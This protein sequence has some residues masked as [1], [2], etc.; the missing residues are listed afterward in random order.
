VPKVHNKP[1]KRPRKGSNKERKRQPKCVLVSRT[2]LSGVPPDSVQC[3]RKFQSEL[4]TFGNSGSRSSIIHRTVRC[5]TGLSGVAPDYPVRQRSNGYTT[6]TVVCKNN[7]CTTVRAC[8]CRSQD[9][10]QKAHRTVN[11]DCPVHHRTVRLPSCQ[12]LQRSEPNDRVTWLAHQTVRCAMGH[13]PPPTGPLV[14]GAINTLNHPSFIASKFSAFTPHTR[15]I[16]FNTRHKQEIKSSPKSKDH[17]NQIVTSERD[18]CVLLSSCA[19]IA[20]LLPPFLIPT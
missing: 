5:S 12:K 14:V 16:A 7:K 9:R 13:Q 20:F 3:T 15:A 18:N 10:R 1:I 4:A 6:P 2:E 19:W 8:A 11:N 17:S